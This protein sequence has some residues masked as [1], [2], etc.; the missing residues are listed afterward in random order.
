MD[1]LREQRTVATAGPDEINIGNVHLDDG[2]A[3]VL[4]QDRDALVGDGP[5]RLQDEAVCV[6]GSNLQPR[7]PVRLEAPQFRPDEG[8]RRIRPIFTITSFRPCNL[9]RFQGF[10]SSKYARRK[11][12]KNKYV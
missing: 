2:F 10:P 12:L 5:I 1:C 7:V 6:A 3:E 9:G 4:L 8:R 11:N